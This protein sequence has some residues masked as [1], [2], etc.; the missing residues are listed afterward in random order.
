MVDKREQRTVLM[1]FRFTP[2]EAE[3]LRDLAA[4]LK[5]SMTDVVVSGVNRL[6][7]LHSTDV[8]DGSSQE[9]R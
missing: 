4:R 9:C 3:D 5:T 2:S 7:W 8:D 1:N 6:V